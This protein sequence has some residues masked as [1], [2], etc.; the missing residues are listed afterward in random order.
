MSREKKWPPATRERP[1]PNCGSANRC[2]VAPDG[3]AAVCWR[4]GGK[5]VQC[6]RGTNGHSLAKFKDPKPKSDYPGR[7]YG[8]AADAI[9]AAAR[10]VAGGVFR[11]AWPYHAPDGAEVMQVA[12]FDLREGGKEFRPVHRSK[13][14]WKVGDPS[15]PL[16]LFRGNELPATGP[17]VVV[18]G[19]KATEA[20]RSIGLSAVTSAHGSS[21]AG[22]SNWAP[23]AGRDVIILPDADEPGRKYARDVARILM[24]LDP[25]ARVKIVELPGLH[26]GEDIV[27]FIAAN[28]D[29]P[30]EDVEALASV[31][32]FIDPAT[33]IGGP[34]L[35]CMADVE[36]C[37]VKWMWPGRI[38]LG[39]ISLLV[40]R[41]GEGKS[42]ATCDWAARVST[43]TPWPDGEPC[44]RGSVLLICAEDDGGDTIRPRLDAHHADASRIHLLAMVRSVN[45]EGESREL[46]FTLSDVAALEAAMRRI[47][48]L[49]LVVI[50]P[51]GSYL[52]GRLDASRD[53]EVRS[54][55]APIAALAAKYG[56]AVLVVAHDRKSSAT[57]ADDL[58]MGSRAFTGIARAVWHLR[59]DPEDK[60]RRLLLPGKNNLAPEG[61][62]LAFTIVGPGQQAAILWEDGPVEMSADEALA[63]E[64][65]GEAETKPGPDPEKREMAEKWLL[66]ELADW[67]EHP[68]AVV[69]QMAELAGVGSWKTV[70]RA[71]TKIGVLSH[72]ATFGGGY[73]WRLP[74]PGA[75][76]QDN[77]QDSPTEKQGT[78]PPVPHDVSPANTTAGAGQVPLV[79]Q[80]IFSVPLGEP[81]DVY[82]LA[83]REALS[84]V[85]M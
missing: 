12:R 69:R 47:P 14:R 71:A 25:P 43:G 26:D 55:L 81:V 13:G 45:D 2:C 38:P 73:I 80:D 53:N 83:E 4:D 60:A 10:S 70:Q 9:R 40:G 36:P 31:V 21:S 7:T 29:T 28:P 74:K 64:V 68:V 61:D 19:E 33:L 52:G 24:R 37:E 62:G 44:E 22:K 17:V 59:R 18:E 32:P 3:T 1:C 56:P 23:L 72:R 27:E 85:G 39:R 41:P 11:G 42:F 78:C 5:V 20:A 58:V 16:P 30:R 82:E 84:E 34:V 66:E 65:E 46:V 35:T 15:G 77:M 79:G 63:A 48:D 54:V 49:R 51:I 57:H 50:D 75:P 6:G 8:T 67:Q 76:M